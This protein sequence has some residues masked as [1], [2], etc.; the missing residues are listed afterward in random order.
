MAATAI[1]F[2]IEPLLPQIIVYIMKSNATIPLRYP[3]PIYW[4]GLDME[5]NYILI[6]CVSSFSIFVIA[7]IICATDTT[8]IFQLQHCCGLFAV[9]SYQIKNPPKSLLYEEESQ[10]YRYEDAQYQHY[11]MCIKNHKRAIEYVN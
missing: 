3:A 11:I 10:S 1:F 7:A 9:V 6:W 4:I 2:V 8:L 5:K